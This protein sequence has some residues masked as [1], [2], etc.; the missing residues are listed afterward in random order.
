MEF[1][2]SDSSLYSDSSESY[3][4]EVTEDSS[5]QDSS[6]TEDEGAPED[7]VETRSIDCVVISSDE[8]SMELEPPATPSAPL[9]PG[10]QL[11][12]DLREWSERDLRE[13]PGGGQ[14]AISHCDTSELD[15]AM[16]FQPSASPDHL[17]PPSPIGVAGLIY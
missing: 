15:I 1:S 5:Y 13:A 3:S 14:R 4:S 2:S 8:E 10:A 11:D 6:S 17:R 7:S 16:E 12:L 9:T